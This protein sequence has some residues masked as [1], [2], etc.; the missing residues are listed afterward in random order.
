MCL[1]GRDE[2]SRS[3]PTRSVGRFRNLFLYFTANVT[4]METP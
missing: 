4:V 1:S 2:I 3:V